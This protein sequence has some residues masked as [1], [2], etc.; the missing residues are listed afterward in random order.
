MPGF[1]AIKTNFDG[2][3]PFNSWHSPRS[4]IAGKLEYR[5]KALTKSTIKSSSRFYLRLK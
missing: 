1:V 4:W 5:Y 2:K 3:Y